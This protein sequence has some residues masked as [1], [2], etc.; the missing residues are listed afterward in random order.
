MICAVP[1]KRRNAIGTNALSK[2]RP[3]PSRRRPDRKHWIPAKTSDPFPLGGVD[4]DGRRLTYA[5]HGNG[6]NGGTLKIS[7]AQATY[8]PPGDWNGS[9]P[10]TD[11][12]RVTTSDFWSGP[13]IHGLSGL[14]NLLTFGLL[15]SSGHTATGT[16]TVSRRA[17]LRGDVPGRLRQ[18]LAL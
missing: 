7:G 12:F 15:G 17:A 11:T 2:P 3:R 13:H 4:T 8:T 14:V 16:V 6:T 1:C 18:Q 9:D 5:V 10:Y